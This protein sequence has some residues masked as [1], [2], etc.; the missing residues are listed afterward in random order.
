MKLKPSFLVLLYRRHLYPAA[1]ARV[2]GL[3]LLRLV[4]LLQCLIE[5]PRALENPDAPES[6]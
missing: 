2:R 5:H 1:S 6:E 3:E 4:S